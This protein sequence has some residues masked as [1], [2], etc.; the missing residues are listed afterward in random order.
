MVGVIIVNLISK[1]VAEEPVEVASPPA[2][3]VRPPV[4][5]DSPLLKQVRAQYKKS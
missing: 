4:P 5:P 2:E 3:V 1:S